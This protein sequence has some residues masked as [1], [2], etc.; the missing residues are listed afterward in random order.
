MFFGNCNEV[1]RYFVSVRQYS[2][3]KENSKIETTITFILSPVNK[4]E[5]FI[6]DSLRILVKLWKL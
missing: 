5:K 4:T 1:L 6:C 3:S 2:I